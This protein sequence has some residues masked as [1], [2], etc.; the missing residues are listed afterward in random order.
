M[1]KILRLV[2]LQIQSFGNKEKSNW[3]SV[4]RRE[5]NEGMNIQFCFSLVQELSNRNEDME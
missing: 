4:S 5:K 3:K 2:L 1:E